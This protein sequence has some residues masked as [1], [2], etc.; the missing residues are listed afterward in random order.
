MDI[1]IY[2]Y[3]G[4]HKFRTACIHYLEGD[5]LVEHIGQLARLSHPHIDIFR[6]SRIARL[7]RSG[8]GT[9]AMHLTLYSRHAPATH[10]SPARICQCSWPQCRQ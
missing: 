2:K 3:L 5:P 9:E 8:A 1:Y 6:G 7:V 10:Q 4:M